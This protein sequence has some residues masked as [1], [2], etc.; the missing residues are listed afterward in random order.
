MPIVTKRK[1]SYEQ[2]EFTHSLFDRLANYLA[3]KADSDESKENKSD[4]HCE[5]SH[6][7]FGHLVNNADSDERREVMDN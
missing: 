3:N 7:L 4:E 5:F 1:L 6:S 2:R